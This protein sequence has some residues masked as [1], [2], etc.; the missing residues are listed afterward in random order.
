MT[1]DVGLREPP[2]V[3]GGDGEHGHLEEL[4]VD[5]IALMRRVRA[6]ASAGRTGRPDRLR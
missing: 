6:A 1:V 5:P 2:Q 4:R 3:S